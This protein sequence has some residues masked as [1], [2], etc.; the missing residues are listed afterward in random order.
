MKTILMVLALTSFMFACTHGG[1]HKRGKRGHH[2]WQMLDA[3]KDGKVSRAEFDKM[4]SDKFNEMDANNDG[5]ITM[6]EK[7]AM[8]RKH[9]GHNHR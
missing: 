3:N 4:H 7:K 1:H 8:K 5:Y 2:K 9:R 6:D